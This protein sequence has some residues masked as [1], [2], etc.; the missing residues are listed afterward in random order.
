MVFRRP[1]FR[2]RRKAK[3]IVETETRW[4]EPGEETAG[5][6]EVFSSIDPEVQRREVRFKECSF[7][8]QIRSNFSATATRLIFQTAKLSRAGFV[9]IGLSTLFVCMN[10][11]V[12][13]WLGKR[14]SKEQSRPVNCP[15][16]ILCCRKKGVVGASG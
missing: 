5:G 2:L 16:K 11:I 6:K 10:A 12:S 13:L 4:R 8:D 9:L 3:S 15:L 14:S 7:S 1:D